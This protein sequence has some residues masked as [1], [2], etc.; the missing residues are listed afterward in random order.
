MNILSEIKE[1]P[2]NVVATAHG[3]IESVR[4]AYN[5]LDVKVKPLIS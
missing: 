3:V 2:H 4:N 5:D 1:V